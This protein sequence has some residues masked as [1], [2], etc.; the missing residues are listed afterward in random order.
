M[1]RATPLLCALVAV[2]SSSQ[3]SA[4]L[5]LSP[6]EIDV[7]DAEQ[8][9]KILIT[10]EGKPVLPNEIKKI[11]SG[12]TKTGD[13][14]PETASGISHFSNYSYMFEFQTGEDGFIIIK[15]NTGL[16][17]IGTYDFFIYTV[18]GT[19]KGLINANLR[20]SIPPLTHHTLNLSEFNYDIELSDYIYGQA[21]SINLSPDKK[22]T[23]SWY[24]D[25]EI[26][27]SGVG[28]T[29]FRG[30][31]E[32][33]SHEISYI[34]RSPDG[35]VVSNWSDTIEVSEEPP[36]TTTVRK[37][38]QVPFSAPVGYS[39]VTWSLD[40]KMIAD[41]HLDRQDKDTR[42]VKFRN[43]GK[44]VLSCL[45]RGSETGDFRRITWSVKVK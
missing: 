42:I 18:H 4:Q 40:G 15:P 10:Y 44:H 5:S 26:H 1:I 23:Y 12:V 24:I 2:L 13:A 30:W 41:N 16:V 32:P 8:S 31:P 38:Y 17:E 7:N 34:A 43:K 39:Q 20:D 45:A 36:I 28:E 19:V 21:V 29:V 6:T 9:K 22:N 35:T 3:L 33:G 37:G 25:G 14:V 11:V 27:S